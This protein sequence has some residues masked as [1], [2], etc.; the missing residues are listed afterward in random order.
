MTFDNLFIF[1]ATSIIC[2]GWSGIN[3]M[4]I[5]LTV[6]LLYYIWS[7]FS[8]MAVGMF[9]VKHK[10]KQKFIFTLKEIKWGFSISLNSPHTNVVFSLTFYK[11]NSRRESR[12]YHHECIEYFKYLTLEERKVILTEKNTLK[13]LLQE[14]LKEIKLQSG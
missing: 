13:H 8:R 2:S 5:I 11:F 1:K 4:K 14:H 3:A 10:L 9:H 7:K 6:L 12:C